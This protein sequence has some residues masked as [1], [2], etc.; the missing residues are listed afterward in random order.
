MDTVH[1]QLKGLDNMDTTD[2]NDVRFKINKEKAKS[3]C[4]ICETEFFSEEFHVQHLKRH[5]KTFHSDDGENDP[6]HKGKCEICEKEFTGKF[7]VKH[8]K[9][10]LKNFHSEQG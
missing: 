9:R 10:H 3:K 5:M 2:E 7:H 4:E 8:L 1:E 6:K